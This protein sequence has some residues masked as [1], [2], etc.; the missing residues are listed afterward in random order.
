M[1]IQEGDVMNKQLVRFLKHA[2][3]CR[4][5]SLLQVLSVVSFMAALH[6][7]VSHQGELPATLFVLWVVATGIVATLSLAIGSSCELD[8]HNRLSND[9]LHGAL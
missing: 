7:A 6:S 3:G 2:A 8:E 1:D 5:V 9:E 4:L